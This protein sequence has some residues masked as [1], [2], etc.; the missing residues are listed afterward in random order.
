MAQWGAVVAPTV[1]FWSL[2]NRIHQFLQHTCIF[3]RGEDISGEDL[4]GHLLGN[5]CWSSTGKLFAGSMDS[6][7]NIWTTGG[8]K[9]KAELGVNWSHKTITLTVYFFIEF[10]LVY[11]FFLWIVSS[12]LQ[13]FWYRSIIIFLCESWQRWKLTGKYNI[14]WNFY[15]HC[16]YRVHCRVWSI[17]NKYSYRKYKKAHINCKQSSTWFIGT[18]KSQYR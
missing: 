10:F 9:F 12:S 7:V 8:R 2:P 1:R 5:V 11:Y 16:S 14:F 4:D 6:L 3:N 17:D 15:K 13:F 18:I